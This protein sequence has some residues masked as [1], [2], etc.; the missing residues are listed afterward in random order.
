MAFIRNPAQPFWQAE[1]WGF[2]GRTE[3]N[4]RDLAHASLLVFAVAAV[5]AGMLAGISLSSEFGI[6][7][8]SSFIVVAILFP[9]LCGLLARELWHAKKLETQV[10]AHEAKLELMESQPH[11]GDN[12]PAGLLIVSPDLRVR[13]ANQKYLENTLQEL[14]EV[15]GWKLGDVLSAEG[16][17]ERART[18]LDCSDPAASCC[19]ETGIRGNR[20]GDQPVH[21]TMARIAPRHGEDRILIVVEELFPDS[22]FRPAEPVEGYVC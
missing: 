11:G 13:F 5:S 19:F 2:P 1:H 17:E 6:G 8:S 21:I 15:L 3:R 14:E 7:E 16:L 4:L 10:K 12:V 20:A 22:S 18:L 9:I